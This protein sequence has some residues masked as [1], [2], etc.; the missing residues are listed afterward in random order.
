[1]HE[2]SAQ[3][4]KQREEEDPDD[5]DKVPIQARHFH[6][7]IIIRAERASKCLVQQPQ[8]QSK[9]DDHMQSM[10][11]RHRKIKPEKYPNF[12][13]ELVRIDLAI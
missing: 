9:P 1:M 12:I 10:Q 8:H 7:H 3:Q 2:M 13:P 6:R 4:I 5:I 11:A